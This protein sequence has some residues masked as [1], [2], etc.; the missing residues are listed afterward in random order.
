M[1]AIPT[2][3]LSVPP[4]PAPTPPPVRPRYNPVEVI[5]GAAPS[6]LRHVVL[7]LGT[8]ALVALVLGAHPLADWVN[9]LPI[10]PVTD[11]L[12]GW[13]QTW[14]D[15]TDAIG[16]G[17]LYTGLQGLFRWFQGLHF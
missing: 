7:S 4:A 6:R 3:R 12:S 11:R 10:N 16:A 9:G 1:N 8:A 17:R 14:Q 2:R 15:W 5:E 13:V